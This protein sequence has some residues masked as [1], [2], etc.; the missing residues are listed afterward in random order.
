MREG[1]AALSCASPP[2]RAAAAGD[3]DFLELG[4]PTLSEED[5][6][7]EFTFWAIFGGPMLLATDVRNMSA[8]K[9]S[10]RARPL[11]DDRCPD[12]EAPRPRSLLSQVVLNAEI[13]AVNYDPL[14]SPGRRGE[15]WGE[16]APSRRP[17]GKCP[18]SSSAVSFDNATKT[19]A[20]AKT[21]AAPG[22]QAV[23]LLNFGDGAA[24]TAVSVSWAELGWP[25]GAAVSLYDLWAHAPL[26]NFSGG[27]AVQ[28]PAHGSAMWRATLLA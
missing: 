11:A 18:P 15:R 22:E 7:T 20:W 24:P 8:W 13:L 14:R 19:Q 1:A 16:D 23:A 28:L 2:P 10:V 12:E 21:L 4:L 3:P 27:H 5:G 6:K 26:G 17:R 25:A 9:Q